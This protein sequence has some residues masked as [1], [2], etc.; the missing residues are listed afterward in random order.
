M[1]I[2]EI[3][4]LLA[5]GFIA[6][7]VNT[8]AGGGSNLTIPIL[9]IMGLPADVANATNRLGIFLQSLTA[10]TK[11]KQQDKLPSNDLVAI[12]LPSLAGGLVGA[13]FAA[14]APLWLLKPLLLGTM[15][16]VAAFML[17][18]SS[19][20]ANENSNAIKVMSSPKGFWGLF[21]AG[22][23][24]GFIQAGVGFLLLIVLASSLRYDLVRANAL[25]LVCS[26]AFTLVALLVFISQ[27]LINWQFGAVLS[28][29]FIG[30]AFYGVKFAINVSA[31]T[32]KYTV[33]ILTIIACIAAFF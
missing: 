24:G 23:Y 32:M 4:L 8:L 20:L 19:S 22:V 14:W 13:V 29:G 3:S 17:F 16:A 27:G 10:V 28:I 21:F 15:I 1:T 7:I 2:I 9:M 6:G 12:L 26:L 5:A 30:G 11:F 31:K 18:Y 25:K 33:F